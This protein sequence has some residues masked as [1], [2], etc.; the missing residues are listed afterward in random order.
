MS[1]NDRRMKRDWSLPML[2]WRSGGSVRLD[3]LE[4]LLH[5]VDHLDGVGARLLAD[6]DADRRRAACRRVAL[7]HF[8]HAVLDAADVGEG[9][10]PSRPR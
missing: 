7:A 6:L 4:P 5:P 1:S 8:L 3:R 9:D 2:I 10:R